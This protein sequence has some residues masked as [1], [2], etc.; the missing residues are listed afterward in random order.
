MMRGQRGFT[1]IELLVV[2]AIIAILMAI[3]IPTLH[4]AREQGKRMVCENN[5]RQLVLGWIVYADDFDGRIMNGDAGSNHGNEIA[6]VQKAWPD[7]YGDPYAVPLSKAVQE[8][9]I[10]N[11]SMWPYIKNLDAYRC[12]T[13]FAGEYITYTVMDS[14]NA[15]PQ[16]GQP[17]GRGPANV[18]DTLINKNRA[19]IKSP[20][21]RIVFVDEGW[22]TPDS[23][24]VHS[25]S[26][27]W[28]DDPTVRHG[29]GVCFGMA[30][31][32]AIYHKWMG[33]TTVKQGRKTER[34]YG[35]GITPVS[36]ADWL[37][38]LTMQKSCWWNL[39]PGYN[40]SYH[41]PLL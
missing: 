2:I 21:Y 13:G 34:Y 28:W 24:A 4:R 38:L 3:L 41:P 7:A 5:L 16:P 17:R 8:Q 19:H 15:Y 26:G 18:I 29:D 23:Y 6:W 22:I 14:M 35:G 1:L 11:G 36:E 9:A 32:R 25:D 10:R 31:G 33:S 39:A 40:P 37:D 20:V 27:T 12:P 30:D